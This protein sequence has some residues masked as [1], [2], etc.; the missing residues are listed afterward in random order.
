MGELVCDG[1]ESADEDEILR[2]RVMSTQVLLSCADFISFE[3]GCYVASAYPRE[4][5]PVLYSVCISGNQVGYSYRIHTDVARL[6]EA[7][8]QRFATTAKFHQAKGTHH[9]P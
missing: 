2:F 6:F 9:W 7:M 5:T 8:P 3:S 1:L 4:R